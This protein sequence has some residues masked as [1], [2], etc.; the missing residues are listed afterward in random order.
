MH[1]N[2]LKQQTEKGEEIEFVKLK[3]ITNK[4]AQTSQHSKAEPQNLPLRRSSR[5]VKPIVRFPPSLHY[6]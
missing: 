4:G 2:R 3:E 1:K 6:S 5:I